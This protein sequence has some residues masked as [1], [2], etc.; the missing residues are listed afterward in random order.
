MEQSS[1]ILKVT[2]TDIIISSVLLLLLVGDGGASVGG[3]GAFDESTIK[4][5]VKEFAVA[6]QIWDLLIVPI[7]SAEG[8]SISAII[9]HFTFA[10]KSNNIDSTT[11]VRKATLLITSEIIICRIRKTLSNKI[12]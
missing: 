3:R 4:L 8:S 11:L 9:W 2:F 12:N 7:S 10:N 6:F 1:P 5:H